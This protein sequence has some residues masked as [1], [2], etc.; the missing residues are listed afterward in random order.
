MR[1][2]HGYID[3]ETFERIARQVRA[4][5]GAP[6][7]DGR[8]PAPEIFPAEGGAMFVGTLNE[9][10]NYRSS[11]GMSVHA[12]SHPLSDTGH[13]L[14]VYDWYLGNEGDLLNTGTRVFVVAISGRL[15]VVSAGCPPE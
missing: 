6:Q 9:Q 11:A 8:E 7:A 12:G 15:Y 14:T 1:N 5:E 2:D 4:A 13:D 3:R 10:L